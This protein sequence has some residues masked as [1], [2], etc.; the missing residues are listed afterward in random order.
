MNTGET[1]HYT[2]TRINEYHYHIQLYQ[3]DKLRTV[4]ITDLGHKIMTNTTNI[5]L[6]KS[7]QLD[8]LTRE[9]TENNV[10]PNTK[11]VDRYRLSRPQ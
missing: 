8:H 6:T 3:P 9:A 10:H 4:N 11:R 5:P 7:R 1:S 2:E